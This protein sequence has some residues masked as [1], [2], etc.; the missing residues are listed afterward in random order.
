MSNDT[1]FKIEFSCPTRDQ[2]DHVLQYLVF[3]KSRWDSWQQRGGSSTELLARVGSKSYATIVSWGFNLTSEIEE[4]A[5]GRASVKATAWAN[6]NSLGNVW[7]SGEDGEIE[8]LRRRFSFLTIEGTYKDE[9]G[10]SE[11]V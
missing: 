8:D 10:N 3:K 7:I 4:D 5:H 2:L 9:Y 11:D 1:D 6:Q